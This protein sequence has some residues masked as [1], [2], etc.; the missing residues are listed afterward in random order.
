MRTKKDV[1]SKQ[2]E[3]D[4]EIRQAEMILFDNG[5]SPESASISQQEK[6]L[7]SDYQTAAYE[8]KL[9][10]SQQVICIRVIQKYNQLRKTI[11]LTEQKGNGIYTIWQ[12]RNNKAYE[13]LLY[14]N[15]RQLMQIKTNTLQY[16]SPSMQ[17]NE[18]DNLEQCIN[19][20]YYSAIINFDISKGTKLSSYAITA[21]LGYCK[22]Y[23]ADIK[24][25]ANVD[26]PENKE[27]VLQKMH[28]VKEIYEKKM[29]RI[30]T[31]EEVSQETGISIKTIKNIQRNVE[32]IVQQS[33]SLDAPIDDNLNSES[34]YDLIGYGQDVEND[35]IANMRNDYVHK[36]IYSLPEI[37]REIII[38]RIGLNCRPKTT[39]EIADLLGLTT[40]DVEAIE[41]RCLIKLGE[42]KELQALW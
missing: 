21:I 38:H 17:Q 15:H 8:M 37:E 7:W 35:V 25:G 24:Y 26:I 32:P 28:E 6:Q 31:I 22:T 27:K 14:Q 33:L 1:A 13:A 23:K 2:T 30:P 29:G 20:W 3:I 4:E 39:E 18:S 19:E 5:V 42:R 36:A 9:T 40:D 12:I 34:L 41:L 10:Q 11:P 16:L